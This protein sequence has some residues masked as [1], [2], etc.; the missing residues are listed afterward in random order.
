MEVNYLKRA[1][2][3]AQNSG[4]RRS[5]RGAVFVRQ[6][7]IL[8]ETFNRVYPVNDFC[9]QAGCLRDK[10]T[11]G[12]GRELEKCRALHAE[13]GAICQA[14][15]QGLS[16][17]GTAAYLTAMPCPNCA[18][19]LLAAG[20]KRVYYLDLYADQTGQTLLRHLGVPCQRGVLAGDEPR[21]R[22]RDARGQR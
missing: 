21:Q 4:C 12:L 22:L 1:A 7:Q 20:V 19:A 9:Q 6:G 18:K 2:Q 15:S 17:Q 8:L 5:K 16:L 13:I 3:V 11:L 14:A 10:L